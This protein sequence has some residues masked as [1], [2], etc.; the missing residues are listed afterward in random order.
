[1]R[2]YLRELS[3]LYGWIQQEAVGPQGS[4]GT[5]NPT[6]VQRSLL[7]ASVSSEPMKKHGTVALPSRRM[8]SYY[9]HG[10]GKDLRKEKWPYVVRDRQ[11]TPKRVDY[12]A[13]LKNR[14]MFL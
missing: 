5:L 2:I 13:H 11:V 7:K 9:F 4:G 6:I 8:S 3:S 12:I 10:K 14:C 1:M